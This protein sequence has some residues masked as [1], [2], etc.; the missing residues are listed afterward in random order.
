MAPRNL[1]YARDQPAG[2]VNRI[3]KIAIV[4]VSGTMGRLFTDELLKGGNHTVTAITRQDSKANI[5][6]GVLIARVDYED[7]GSLVRALEGQQ[8]LIITLNVFAPQDTQ[9][10]L[11]RAA[12][13]AG[14]PYVMPN[15]WGPDPANE[16]LLAESLLGPLFQ[17]AVE[18]IEQLC[19]SEWIIMSCGFWYEFS[20]GGSP[21]RYGFDMKRKSLILFDDGS[22]KIT[23]STFAQCGRAIARFLSLKWLPEDENDESPSLQK[24]ANDVFY[25]S[26]FLVSQKD[27]FESVKRV[28]NTTDADWKITHENTQERWKAGKLALQAGDR[29]GFS[30]MMYT[31]IF[32]PSG[33]GDFESK[34]GLANEAIGLPQ[35]DL[36][37]ATTEGI[38]MALSGEL[39]NYS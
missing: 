30:K 23:T 2:F 14:V 13:K 27:M 6:E 28:T 26:S 4:G 10:K 34:Y 8:Y 9:T 11:V 31:R 24:W 15:C 19:V 18:E 3:E 35:D 20:L 5:P 29:N 33:D 32:Y 25:I 37:A 7:E 1:R 16:A 38:R 21:N 17:G 12:A 36:D 22:V 39:D